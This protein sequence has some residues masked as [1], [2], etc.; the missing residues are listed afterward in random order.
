MKP[1]SPVEIRKILILKWSAM[2]DVV[3]ASAAMEDVHRAFPDASIDLHT[4]KP[5]KSLFAEDP[6]F[7][8]VLTHDIRSFKGVVGWLNEIRKGRYDLLI[9]LQSNDRSCTLLSLLY[10]TGCAPKYRVGNHPRF[11][12]NFS[13]GLKIGTPIAAFDIQKR[14]LVAIGIESV[15]KR[16]C[17]YVPEVNHQRAQAMMDRYRLKAQSFVIFFPGSQAAGYLK[18]WGATSYAEL[19]RELIKHGLEK[20]VL[21]GGPD[22]SEVCAQVANLCSSD[23]LVNLCGQTQIFDIVPLCEHAELIIGNDTGTSHVASCTKTPMLVICGPTDPRR[24][25]PVGDQIE[26]IQAEDKCINCYK[27][28]CRH[29]VYHECMATITVEMVIEKLKDM[30]ALPLPSVEKI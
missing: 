5:W 13:S 30:Q 23:W 16:P 27:K 21:V 18:R 12:Y 1:V 8:R 15:T 25:K 11:P 10:L 9:D 14:A 26:S 29:S 7:D 4:T 6:R 19:G 2:G 24:V 20:I 22:D 17:L 28:E 3:I